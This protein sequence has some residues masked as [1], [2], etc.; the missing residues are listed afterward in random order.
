VNTGMDFALNLPL[1][2]ILML[3]RKR[4]FRRGKKGNENLRISEDD[5]VC[6]RRGIMGDPRDSTVRCYN[7]SI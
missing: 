3:V 6:R 7:N 5:C 1:N 2:C 4:H